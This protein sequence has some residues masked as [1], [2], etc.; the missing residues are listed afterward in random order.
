MDENGTI[1]AFEISEKTLDKF[2]PSFEEDEDSIIR[3]DAGFAENLAEKLNKKI[4]QLQIQKPK[5]V[6]PLE[7]RHLMFTLLSSYMNDITVLSREE[8]GCNA[9]LEIIAEI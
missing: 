5:L 8:I 9:N 1:T 2:L 6:V 3:I 7:L 4:K